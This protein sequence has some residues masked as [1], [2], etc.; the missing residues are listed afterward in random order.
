MPWY[1]AFKNYAREEIGVK[2]EGKVIAFIV[3]HGFDADEF[4]ELDS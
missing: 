2:L 3:D 4:T 1:K